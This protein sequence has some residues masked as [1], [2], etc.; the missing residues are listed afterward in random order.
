MPISL[1]SRPAQFAAL[2]SAAVGAPYVYYNGVGGN[3]NVPTHAL[4]QTG[5]L[6]GYASGIQGSPS[7]T[8]NPYGSPAYTPSTLVAV[9]NPAIRDLRHFARF[10][11]TP[12]W[13]TG[14]F[15]RVTTVLSNVQMDGL[16]VPVVTGTAPSDFAGTVDYYFDRNQQLRRILLQGYC[17]DPT[18]LTAILLQSYNLKVEPS[19]GGHLYTSR[20]NNRVTSLAMIQP[21]PVVY[22]NDAYR[23]Y[24]V[25]IELNQPSMEYGLSEQSEEILKN[26]W[27]NLRWQ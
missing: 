20:W 14:T 23:K 13:V 15:P 2:L 22:A 1:A 18:N 11:V 27:Q 6:T 9:T 21:A 19:L 7:A 3:G 5:V 12:G 24:T 8:S 10:D 16:R 4:E 26:S 17:G 25:F